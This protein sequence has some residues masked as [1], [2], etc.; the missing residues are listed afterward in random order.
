[1]PAS[2][3]S[4]T[5]VRWLHSTMLYVHYRLTTKNE[6]HCKVNHTVVT[7]SIYA[8]QHSLSYTLGYNYGS[9]FG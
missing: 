2:V 1:M 8:V 4:S 9:G 6:Y 5:P 7:H 3:V